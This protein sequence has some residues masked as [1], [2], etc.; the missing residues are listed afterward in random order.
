MILK[1]SLE[2]LKRKQQ[3]YL[4]LF[5]GLIISVAVFYMFLTMAL[6][7]EFITGNSVINH[8]QLVFIVGTVLLSII[9]FF[10]LFYTNSFLLSLRKKEFGMYELIGAKKQQIKRVFLLETM[11]ISAAAL[12][13]G[14]LFGFLF[15]WLVSSLLAGQLNVEFTDF[16][17][18]YWPAVMATL[19][20]FL[21]TAFA[22]SFLN[23][24]KLAKASIIE[25]LKAEDQND[26]LPAKPQSSIWLILA[27]L[28]FLGTG[29]VSLYFMEILRF[30]GLFTASAAT[31]A[32]TYL[33]FASLLP[34][35]VRKWK[36]NKKMNLKGLNSFTFSQLSFRLNELKW[37]LATI[38]MLIALSAGAIAGGFAFKNNAI[39]S[40][41]EER[42][43]DAALYNPGK[44][45]EE[46]LAAIPLEE[47][48]SYR[49]KMDNEFVYYVQEELAA[50]PPLIVDWISYETKRADPLPPNIEMD[51]GGYQMLGDVWTTALETIN[52]GFSTLG[53]PRIVS[54]K[55][56]E[57]VDA[58]E[59]AIVLARS[60][61]FSRYLAQWQQLD[62]LQLKD[63]KKLPIPLDPEYD[64][65]SS[66]YSHFERQYAFA[67]G[68]FFMGFFLGL[69]FL[70]MMASILMFKILS[71]ANS[72]IRRYDSLRKLGVRNQALNASIS[73]EIFIIFLFPAVL[74]LLHVFVGMR[75]FTFIMD[76]PYYRLWISLLIF[77]AIYG[78]YYFFTVHLYRKLV[79]PKG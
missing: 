79:L 65:L 8:I 47:R 25:L 27:G 48:L 46:I 38:A 2:G 57:Q 55:A 59:I 63:G 70:T 64:S 37:V 28:L 53:M 26:F 35:I 62:R 13:I 78:S 67:S 41:D 61:H 68:T 1:L 11:L 45:E 4:I 40:I 32:G 50:N 29:Y 9:T 36:N 23:N 5:T 42:L 30:I 18:V 60:D 58:E 22:I 72:D 17:I 74:G 69:A 43:Y 49:F 39:T 73:K 19:L 66:K 12:A 21:G 24:R 14:I 10:Y 44:A 16:K 54:K 71:G 34:I 3:D 77:L 31:T 52:P 76:D 75:M 56:F 6:N 7:K 33:L 51:E 20:Y 15:S